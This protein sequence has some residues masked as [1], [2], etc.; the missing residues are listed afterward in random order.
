M[1]MPGLY[2]KKAGPSWE[3]QRR[4]SQTGKTFLKKANQNNFTSGLT[5]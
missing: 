2:L 4:I 3:K 1:S 5:D